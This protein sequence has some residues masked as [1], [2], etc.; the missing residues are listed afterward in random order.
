MKKLR[1]VTGMITLLSLEGIKAMS[2]VAF[3]L[4]GFTA[5]AALFVF[6]LGLI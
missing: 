4:L 3:M 1:F 2:I 5:L 6:I